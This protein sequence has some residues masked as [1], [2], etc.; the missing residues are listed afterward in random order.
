MHLS[1]LR[2]HSFEMSKTLLPFIFKG[3]DI[4]DIIY[5]A[6]QFAKDKRSPFKSMGEWSNTLIVKLYYFHR[7]AQDHTWFWPNEVQVV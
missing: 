6:F 2:H 4:K 7:E 3:I 1:H 5:E